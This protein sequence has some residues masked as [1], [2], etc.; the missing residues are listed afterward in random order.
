MSHSETSVDSAVADLVEPLLK[1]GSFETRTAADALSIPEFQE[2]FAIHRQELLHPGASRGLGILNLHR[3]GPIYT[4]LIGLALVQW[5]YR[6]KKWGWGKITPFGKHVLLARI[7]RDL[8]ASGA[9]PTET[10]EGE[11][12]DYQDGPA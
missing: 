9:F 2:L 8:L 3:D 7:E 1:F 6:T 4:R 5:V 10:Y 12:E 11:D